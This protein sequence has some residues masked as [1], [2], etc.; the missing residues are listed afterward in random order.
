MNEAK[1]TEHQRHTDDWHEWS[2]RTGDDSGPPVRLFV[3][4]DHLITITE[5]RVTSGN[6]EARE[7][8]HPPPFSR[9]ILT[10]ESAAWLRDALTKALVASG[11]ERPQFTC[12]ECGSH[13]FQTVAS[14]EGEPI[15]VCDGPTVAYCRFEWRSSDDAKYG[16]I[17]GSAT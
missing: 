15:R 17:G 14:L 3:R 9:M 2:I 5:A 11:D 13:S 4:V 16:L 1:S 8:D 6:N 10:G 7:L 12:P